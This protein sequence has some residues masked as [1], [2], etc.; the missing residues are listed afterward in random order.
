MKPS[1]FKKILDK[2]LKA[3]EAGEFIAND[4]ILIPYGFSKK[5]DIEISGF[6]AATLAWGQ[7]TTII[8]NCKKLMSLMDH[9]PHDFITQHQ[10]KDLQRF[11]GFVHRTFQTTDLLYFIA[12]LQQ[13][14]KKHS[15]L[16]TAFTDGIKNDKD[17]DFVKNML[18]H[19][20]HYFFSLEFAPERTR[21][22]IS[23]PEKN[24]ACKR[25]NMF[26]RWMV[27]KHQVDFGIWNNISP[28]SLIC[29]LDVHVHKA[30]SEFHLLKQKNADWKAAIELT[31]LLQ[32]FDAEDPVR[33]DLALFNLGKQI[34]LKN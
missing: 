3:F 9:A 25:I 26:L 6:F 27:R 19:F 31:K 4:P 12:F 29:P 2:E 15:S 8:A 32:S 34:R 23:T 7:R 21:K 11:E 17:E 22:H 20:H 18:I 24:S 10:D 30:V 13:H 16:E 33:Y 1:E 5:Q 28:S 14:Y